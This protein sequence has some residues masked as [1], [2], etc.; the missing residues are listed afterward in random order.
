MSCSI[1]Y[2]CL[3]SR[4]FNNGRNYM[5]DNKQNY[6]MSTNNVVDHRNYSGGPNMLSILDLCTRDNRSTQNLLSNIDWLVEEEKVTSFYSLPD[7]EKEI[8]VGQLISALDYPEEWMANCKDSDMIARSFAKYMSTQK[9]C[10]RDY[11]LSL[12]KANAVKY[13]AEHL[14]DFIKT[15]KYTY[16]R[17][18]LDN[19]VDSQI[20]HKL[21]IG[22]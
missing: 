4:T 15:K 22:F 11:Y 20:E 18:S 3:C 1:E 19:Y 9:E 12:Y 8:L 14:D 17:S 16:Q 7:D 21:V 10:D 2:I 6:I 5:T 13:W